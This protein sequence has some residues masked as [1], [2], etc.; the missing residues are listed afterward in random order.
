MKFSLRN[1]RYF[2]TVAEEGS[3]TAAARR[4]YVAQPSVS[5][6]IAQLERAFDQKLFIRRPA[7][8]LTLTPTGQ[9]LL[10]EARILLA[11]AEEFQTM[12]GTLDAELCGRLRMACFTNLGPAYFAA[13]LSRFRH[14][15]PAVEVEF[16][17]GDQAEILDGVRTARFELALT[18]DLRPLDDFDVVELA[19]IPPHAV[20]CKSHPLAKGSRVSLRK[21]A[22]EPLILMD[23]PHSREYLLSLFEQL[24]IR[25]NL[26][27]LPASFEMVRALAG[28]G[29]GYG[30]LNL[31]PRSPVTYDGTVVRSLP[32][33]EK[34]RPL[35]LAVVRLPQ[36][37]VRRV[38][39]AFVEFAREYFAAAVPLCESAITWSGRRAV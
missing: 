14:R 36:M 5:A 13:L 22:P 12:A 24:H 19:R 33:V 6:A 25:P 3:V 11:H 1:L 34:V 23:M 30:L 32:L 16:H 38:T 10:P 15:Y 35:R 28:N 7:H 27:Y 37:P 18:F 31:V 20:L 8:G 26:R 39:Q 17:D 29:L 4:L 2:V 21:L 9:Q